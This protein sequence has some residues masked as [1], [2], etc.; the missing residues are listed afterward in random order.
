MCL[1]WPKQVFQ[2]KTWSFPNSNQVIFKPNQS[3]SKV[4]SWHRIKIIEP[5]ERGSCNISVVGRNV[6]YID[7]FLLLGWSK[8]KKQ[9]EITV[10]HASTHTRTDTL[11]PVPVLTDEL[12]LSVFA[13]ASAPV[14][15][16]P[17]A[18]SPGSRDSGVLPVIPPEAEA[19]AAT[20]HQANS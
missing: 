4:L 7:L 18:G 11:S 13:L 5:K 14:G 16:C 17:R 12:M 8:K 20:G 1:W 6:H 2:T 15:W 3:K 9:H 19:E 10:L